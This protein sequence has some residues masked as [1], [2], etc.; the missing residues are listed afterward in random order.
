VDHEAVVQRLRALNDACGSLT[1]ARSLEHLYELIVDAVWDLFDAHNC[2]IL[3]LD[4]ERLVLTIAHARGYDPAVVD[5]FEAPV[6]HGLTG[7]AARDGLLLYVPDVRSDDRYIQGV[8]GAVSELAAPLRLGDKVIGV[9]DVESDQADAFGELDIELFTTFA[10]HAATAI[11]NCIAFGSLQRREEELTGRLQELLA[12]SRVGDTIVGTLD[13][14][15]LL[16]EVLRV[17]AEVLPF[18]RCAIL[19]RTRDDPD[20]LEAVA[21]RGY[22]ADVSG[23]AIRFG[24]GIT[25]T[26]AA[27]AE[28][29]LVPDVLDD[30]RY[31]RGVEGGRCEMAVP[32]LVR[33]RLLGVIDAEHPEPDGFSPQDL[34]L[35]RTFAAHVAVAVRNAQLVRD[36]ESTTSSLERH[37]IEIER[38]NDEL[39]TYSD[40]IRTANFDLQRR[41]RELI[42]VHEASKTITSSLDL[43]Q[44]LDA[45]V[46]MTQQIIPSTVSAIKL[47]DPDSGEVM[48]R[49]MVDNRS[50]DDARA[51]ASRLEAPLTVGPRV[52]GVFE[53]AS[54]EAEAFA[55]G[56]QQLLQTLASQA[57]IAI[58]NARLFENAQQTYFDTIRSLAQALEARDAYTRGHSERVTM[59][60]LSVAR[61]LEVPDE[62]LKLIE[63]AGLLHDIGKIG[64]SDTILNKPGALDADD[65]RIIESHPSFGDAILGPLKFLD[66]VQGLVLHHHER[67]DGSG[68]PGG[69]AGDQIPLEARIIAVADAFDAM[70]SD[71]PYRKALSLDEAITE[72][73]SGSGSQFDPAVV[74][75]FVGLLRD[76]GLPSDAAA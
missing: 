47:T 11:N 63:H 48:V 26:V 68:Y 13:L 51:L 28:P 67:Y 5:S 25:G 8:S 71:R 69:L 30:A 4:R 53:L 39:S 35:L 10:I 61:A 42:T 29:L 38:M 75:A 19:L 59:Y 50:A 12:V 20:T 45:I 36:L 43:D 24:E 41:V 6:G 31:I 33:G 58:E 40:Q 14:D 27:T 55:E 2:A 76:G 37:V 21:V 18:E 72:L 56:D 15:T 49:A 74:E 7:A 46:G 22:R 3:L 57:A 32:L 16:G 70:T 17:A 73:L 44:T 62:R 54:V 52:I 60:S 64:I 65:R 66:E 9:V 1:G 34:A 23:K